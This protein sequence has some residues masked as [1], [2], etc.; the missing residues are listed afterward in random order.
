MTLSP[1]EYIRKLYEDN[2]RFYD[3]PRGRG[4]IKHLEQTFQYPW[5][6]IAELIQNAIDVNATR[7]MFKVIDDNTLLFEHNG[8]CFVSDDVMS[9]CTRGITTKSVK[10]IGFMGVGFKS[11]FKPKFDQSNGV[12][13]RYGL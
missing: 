7:L 5:I 9:L 12:I 6:Y 3:D 13:Y 8:K 4:A 1:D 11:V 10:T 2:R